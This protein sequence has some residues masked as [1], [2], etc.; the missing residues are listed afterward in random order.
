VSSGSYFSFLS[1]IFLEGIAKIDFRG[2]QGDVGKQ[3]A[4]FGYSVPLRESHFE[5]RTAR[6]K[7]AMGYNGEF[8]VDPTKNELRQLDI[9]TDDM[10]ETALFCAFSSKTRYEV[11]I[12]NGV[13]FQ[14]PASVA[15]DILYQSHE[16]A[17]TITQY[18]EC[19]EFSAESVLRFGDVPKQDGRTVSKSIRTLPA[20]LAVRIRIKTGIDPNTAWTGDPV[21]GELATDIVDGQGKVLAAR[22]APA[23]GILI[24]LETGVRPSHF[25]T[26]ALKFRNLSAAGED[27]RLNLKSLAEPL[28]LGTGRDSMPSRIQLDTPPISDDPAACRFRFNDKHIRLKGVVTYWVTN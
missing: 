11:T 3:V 4:V 9:D 20:G 25:Y 12:L 23:Q 10:P 1:S 7:E 21:E 26:A 13:A 18:R 2:L 14:L 24:R 5:T 15:A 16:R 27:Y 6:G 17:R 8:T 22:G 28:S 19:R